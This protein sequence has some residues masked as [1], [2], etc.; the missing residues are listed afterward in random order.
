VRSAC[1]ATTK[2]IV[3]QRVNVNLLR[4]KAKGKNVRVLILLKNMLASTFFSALAITQ[5]VLFS[6]L[7]LFPSSQSMAFC[8]FCILG[9]SAAVSS[10]SAS[11]PVVQVGHLILLFVSTAFHLFALQLTFVALLFIVVYVGAVGVL[12]LSVALII[13]VKSGEV[14][15]QRKEVQLFCTALVVPFIILAMQDTVNQS[16][17]EL[18]FAS[19][20]S[21]WLETVEGL[22]SLQSL[23]GGKLL[24]ELPDAVWER[25]LRQETMIDTL[26]ALIYTHYLA[27]FLICSIL[28]LVA[29]IG[30]IALT[31]HR[32]Q[33]VKRTTTFD[34]NT[35]DNTKTILKLRSKSKDKSGKL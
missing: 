3:G 10:I 14:N 8:V 32:S 23:T 11:N 17:N 19:V 20:R 29:M 18:Q 24:P 13:N 15:H 16:G 28:L 30:A 4:S 7:I 6:P 27:P 5:C 1:K 12:F 31:L 9:L 25:F 22:P 35:R 26:G 2:L 34:Q 33:N 21:F